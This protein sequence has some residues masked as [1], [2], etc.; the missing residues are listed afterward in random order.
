MRSES[1]TG[2]STSVAAKVACEF[3]LLE[4]RMKRSGMLGTATPSVDVKWTD[5]LWG[6]CVVLLWVE[7]PPWLRTLVLLSLRLSDLPIIVTSLVPERFNEDADGFE[8]IE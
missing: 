5:C 4:G 1:G 7:D 6:E 2:A 8:P 3:A